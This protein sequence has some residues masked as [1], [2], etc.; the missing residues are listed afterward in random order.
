[1]VEAIVNGHPLTAV[2]YDPKD[3]GT[4]TSNHLLLLRPGPVL[5]PGHSAKEVEG[6]LN[7]NGREVLVV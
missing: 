7:V 1:M 3:L 6:I 5:P 2:S 4:L